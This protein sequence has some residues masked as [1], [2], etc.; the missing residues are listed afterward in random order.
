MKRQIIPDTHLIQSFRN[1]NLKADT[2]IAEFIDNSFVTAKE[3]MFVIHPD[4]IKAADNGEGVSNLD[5]I[6]GL[7]WSENR[8]NSKNIGRFGIG[9][10]DAQLFFGSCCR[11]QTVFQNVYYE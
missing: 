10:K 6:F 11:V 5:N 9:S 8:Y 2:V 7:A 4:Y 1:K 3:F